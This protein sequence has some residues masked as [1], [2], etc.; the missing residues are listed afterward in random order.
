MN[1]NLNQKNIFG[2]NEISSNKKVVTSH[3]KVGF[4]VGVLTAVVADI[5]I[6]VIF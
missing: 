1:I 3:H 5:V 2:K 6:W 4:F